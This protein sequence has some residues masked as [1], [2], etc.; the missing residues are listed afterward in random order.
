MAEETK[1]KISFWSGLK[2]EWNKIIW[3]SPQN[4]G[5]QSA[6]VIAVS[7]VVGMIIVILDKIINFGVEFLVNL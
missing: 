1:S 2:A 7:L 6:A 4:V 5:K 3:Q